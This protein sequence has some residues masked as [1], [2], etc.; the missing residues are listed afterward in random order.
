MSTERTRAERHLKPG[1]WTVKTGSRSPLHL[2]YS[3]G[4]LIDYVAHG[5]VLSPASEK[6][7]KVLIVTRSILEVHK[8]GV[9]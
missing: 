6:K 2:G 7:L 4:N 1:S 9:E 3:Q 5:V 8:A